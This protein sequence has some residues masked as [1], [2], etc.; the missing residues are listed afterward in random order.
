MSFVA[1]E[2]VY[3][4]VHALCMCVCTCNML[5]KHAIPTWQTRTHLKMDVFLLRLREGV[6]NPFSFRI[7]TLVVV[8]K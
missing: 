7:G 1:F 5:L 8:H 2:S 3:V 6:V 4:H